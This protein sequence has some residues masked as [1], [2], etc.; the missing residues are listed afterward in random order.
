MPRN[1]L[2]IFDCDGVLVDSEPLANGLLEAALLPY[3]GRDAKRMTENSIGRS[4]ADIRQQIEQRLPDELP[5]DFWTQLQSNTLSALSDTLQPDPALRGLLE[6]LTVPIC[7]ASSGSHEKIRTSL[8]AAQ[9]LDL[10]DRAIFSAE[11]VV[12]GKPAPDLFLLAA[13]RHHVS[14]QDCLVIEDSIPG[15]EAARAAGMT[16]LHFVPNEF[17]LEPGQINQ[18]HTLTEHL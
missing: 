13:Q 18:L 11:D 9:L 10:F 6:G 15:L 5:Q 2:I 16:A 17:H 1:Q 12:R 3:F 4:F 8:A 14:H 7:V